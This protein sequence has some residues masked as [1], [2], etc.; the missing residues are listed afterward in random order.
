MFKKII[1]LPLLSILVCTSV[2]AKPQNLETSQI[3]AAVRQ[4]FPHLSEDR[5]P[6]VMRRITVSGNYALVSWTQYEM[7][8]QAALVKKKGKWIVLTAGGGAMDAA[9]LRDK[10]VPK[11][12]AE[13]LYKKHNEPSK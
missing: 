7:G 8:G 2:F 4:G 1:I 12:T 6:L 13:A 5:Y 9:V 11:A 10:G 3:S